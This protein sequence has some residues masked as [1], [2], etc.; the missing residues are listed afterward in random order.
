M[1]QGF[2]NLAEGIDPL[3]ER[4][5]GS[6]YN[7]RDDVPPRCGDRGRRLGEQREAGHPRAFPDQV[8]HIDGGFASGGIAQRDQ[9]TAE[10]K[11]AQCLAGHGPADAP[12]DDIDTLAGRYPGATSDPLV[13][14]LSSFLDGTIDRF[15]ELI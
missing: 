13:A 8:R 10:A 14:A 15:D 3:D 4:F 5:G 11:A 12:D 2:A 1:T 7:Q 6:I 9:D